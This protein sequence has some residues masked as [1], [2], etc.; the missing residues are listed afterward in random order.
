MAQNTSPSDVSDQP[1]N[2]SKNSTDA[3]S[4][5]VKLVSEAQSEPN[6]I[7]VIKK[8][9]T[10]FGSLNDG[11]VLYQPD[12]KGSLK[13]SL[14]GTERKQAAA[15][16]SE[17]QLPEASKKEI[18]NAI[19]QLGDPS[20]RVRERA[21]H[22]LQQH[23]ADAIPFLKEATNAPDAE[24][25]HRVKEILEQNFRKFSQPSFKNAFADD[26]SAEGHI[27]K[28][29]MRSDLKSLEDK[30]RFLDV[31][32]KTAA[33]RSQEL[34]KLISSLGGPASNDSR[35]PELLEQ[36][37]D[38]KN[39]QNLRKKAQV[40]VS[41][42]E[43]FTGDANDIDSQTKALQRFEGLSTLN[44]PSKLLT[45]KSLD[46][47][48][49]LKNLEYLNIGGTS[50]SDVG[51]SKI[52]EMSK[53]K[54]LGLQDT[55]VTDEGVK[56][57]KGLANISGINLNGTRITDKALA[58]ISGLSKID[59]L[60][61]DMTNVTD[62]GLDSLAKLPNLKNLSISNTKISN[63]GLVKL[64]EFKSLEFLSLSGNSQISDEAIDS[65]KKL[66]GL[67]YLS[68]SGTSISADGFQRLRKALPNAVVHFPA[69]IAKPEVLPPEAN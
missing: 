49:E 20:F 69:R 3:N 38:Y 18:V 30:V 54:G 60:S 17:S 59:E 36:Q 64:E 42:L 65:L 48:K 44:L 34:T 16:G 57:L 14:E 6:T 24:S 46:A 10:G 11:F 21:S 37:S 66:K 61:I 47:V 51:L 55:A 40:Y 28:I 32:D 50:I 67:K 25:R 41:Q 8:M 4:T 19:S 53:L 43:S 45:D 1:R 39:I 23:G 33:A 2:Q 7:A 9:E 62:S 29:P 31:D 5:R 27:F 35:V 22:T 12:E 58:E 68:V 26:M 15:S 56:N 52:S 13:G 63:E